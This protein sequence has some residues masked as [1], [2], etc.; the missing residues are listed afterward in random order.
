[1]SSPLRVILEIGP[2][3]RVAAGA[4]DWPG[5]DRWGTSEDDALARLASYRARYAAVAERAGLASEFETVGEPE[6]VERVPGSSSTDWWGVAH[7]PSQIEAEVLSEVD[8][9]R[10]ISLLQ[11]GWDHFDEVAARVSAELRKGARGG[12]RERDQIIRHVYV[13]ERHNWWRKVGI[14]ADDDV[15]LSPDELAAYR[16]QYVAAIRT[17]NAEARLARRWPIQF[18][19]RRTAQ[20]VV[21][22]AWEMED[23]DL[24]R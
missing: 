19:V 1:M 10:R 12:G 14:R 2:K 21:D 23:R 22:H 18:L 3:R 7:I 24:S 4:M 9:E 5:L 16:Q 8:L 11:A 17:H 20:H 6:V 15:R 13:S